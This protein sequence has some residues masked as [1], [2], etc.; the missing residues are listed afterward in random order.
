M[1][2]FFV[3]EEKYE[4]LI[5]MY[6]SYGDDFNNSSLMSLVDDFGIG[7]GLNTTDPIIYVPDIVNSYILRKELLLRNYDSLQHKTLLDYFESKKLINLFNSNESELIDEFSEDFDDLIKVDI[8]RTSG[9]ITITTYFDSLDLS[10]EV[11]DYIYNLSLI[12][13]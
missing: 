11:R 6:P 5:S 3:Q 7:Q 8:G 2:Y 9:L 13:I 10:I 12:H 1:L 4:S